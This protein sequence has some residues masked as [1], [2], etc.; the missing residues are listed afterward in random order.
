[1][2]LKHAPRHRLSNI[3]THVL[4][5]SNVNIIFQRQGGGGVLEWYFIFAGNVNNAK[6]SHKCYDSWILVLI[7]LA[8][9]ELTFVAV[10]GKCELRQTLRTFV[11][12]NNSHEMGVAS[13]VDK[14]MKTCVED[15][16]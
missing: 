4:C 9:F 6:L 8:N 10:H 7:V 5:M 13:V 15:F 11:L 3:S 14:A 1:M 16:N 2:R 12:R